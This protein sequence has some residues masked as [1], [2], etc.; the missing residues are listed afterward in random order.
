MR[1][2]KRVREREGVG[3]EDLNWRKSVCDEVR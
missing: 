3:G 2:G 1:T